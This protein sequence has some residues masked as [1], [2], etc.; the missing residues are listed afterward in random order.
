MTTLQE[1]QL[2]DG[3]AGDRAGEQPVAGV[4]GTGREPGALRPGE[5]LT[6]VIGGAEAGLITPVLGGPGPLD[7]PPMLGTSRCN[8]AGDNAKTLSLGWRDAC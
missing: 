1:D 6:W 8:V 2:N 5:R 4:A 7:V 3:A